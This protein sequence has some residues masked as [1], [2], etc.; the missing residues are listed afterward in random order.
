MKKVLLH[1]GVAALLCAFGG[2]Y[3]YAQEAAIGST[4]YTTLAD[5]FSAAQSGDVISLNEDVTV[6][7]MIPVTTSVSLNLNGHT[8]TN[9]VTANRLFR[10]SDVTFTINGD[11]GSV[12]TPSTNTQ[13]YG[14][15]DFRDASGT[16]GA[17]TSLIVNDTNFEGATNEGSLFAF[18]ANGQS[19]ELNNTNVNLTGG[20]TYSIINGYQLKVDVNVTGGKYVCNSTNT[21]AGVF[22]AGAGSTIDFDGV[23]VESSVGPVFEVI[24]SDATFTDCTMVNTSTNSYFASC[25]AVSNGGTATVKNCDLTANYPLYV[26]NSGGKIN[27]DGGTYTGNVAAIKVD[28][29][30]TT[31]NTS[32]VEVSAGTFKGNVQVGE[33][34]D[35]TVSGGTFTADV[36]E[37]CAENASSYPSVDSEGNTIYMVLPADTDA[38]AAIGSTTYT[39]LEDAFAAA[40][41]GD[42]VSLFKD[43]TVSSMIPVTTSVSLNLNGHTITNDVTANRLFRLSDVTFTINGDGGSVV[44]PSTNTQS[45]G[46][47]DFRDASGT[48]GASTSLIVNDTNFEGATNEGSLFAFR[49]N[50]QS[51]ELNNTNVNLTGGYTYSIIN[52]YQLKVD[53]NVTGGKYVCNSTNT[54]AGVFQAGAGS[55]I[56]F[57]GV[58]VESSVGP[59]FEV[60]QSDATFTDC[61][62][63]NT[64]TNSYF[65]S[66]VAVSNG[67]TATVKNCDLTANY[68]LYVYNSGGKI[69]VDGGTYTGNVAAI[70]VDD[71]TTTTNTSE[72]EVSAGTFKGNLS[73][74]KASALR[75]TGGMFTD[76]SAKNYCQGGYTITGEP[77]EDGLYEVIIDPQTGV[78]SITGEIPVDTAVYNLQGIKIADSIEGVAPGLYICGGKKIIVKK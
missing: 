1:G 54:T 44:T 58:T 65:A 31:T 38:V 40:Q 62:M 45:Y 42:T 10:L 21:T 47:V 4:S 26:Y 5:A 77:N 35:L 43:V 56:D 69:N 14:F 66:C 12:V 41:E 29:S 17:S 72:V 22:Q 55:T 9:D 32:E 71:S 36:S 49:A 51:I 7:S 48:A 59:V 73:V 39:S 8:I 30:T 60:I 64:S 16:A 63:V 13:S 28:D 15:V 70:K 33:K 52:G 23:T 46:F 25:V 68:P 78:E 61:T 20:Y 34:S 50:G 75:I 76:E 18:R 2:G 24:Q 27:V 11:G 3:S 37:Y 19:I 6:S 74:G 57:D 53:V 67:G